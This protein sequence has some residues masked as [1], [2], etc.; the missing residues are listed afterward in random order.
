MRVLLVTHYYSTHAGGIEI[1]AGVLAARLAE[2]H[3]ITW[4]ASD[5]DQSPTGLAPSVALVPMRSANVIERTT[6]LPFPLWGPVSLLRLW[7]ETGRADIVHLHDVAYPG[8]WAAFVFARLR[9]RPV[10][11]TQ[12][13][14]FI[15]Y[16]SLLLRF[17]LRAMHATVGRVMLGGAAQ[18]VFV[19]R[20]VLNY[21]ARF[22]R[23]RGAPLVVSNGVDSTIFFPAGAGD[24][25]RARVALGLDPSRPV[26]LF[27]GRFVEKKGLHVLEALA[28][29]LPEATWALAGWGPKDPT[30]WNA[31]NV[32]VF[33]NRRGAELVPLYHAADL[34]VLPSVGEGL[35]LVVQ[36]AMSCG[37]PA[38]VGEDTA[39]AVEGPPLIVFAA[40]VGGPATAD[41]WEA[42]IRRIL[43]EL[44]RQQGLPQRVADFARMRWSW[45]ACADTYAALFARLTRPPAP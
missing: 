42:A 22:V 12:H 28:R 44:S 7:R 27:V 10:F 17:A 3:H 6:G 8:N 30:E 13:V 36:E 34:L 11:I 18:V 19:S 39:D 14:G 41:A 25:A 29:R 32:R 1:V 21:Y 20:V 37:T 2:T 15:P 5:C 4:V 24:R 38:L 35:P 23:F 40:K 16:K 43:P 26:L 9:R 33:N 31:P 45:N